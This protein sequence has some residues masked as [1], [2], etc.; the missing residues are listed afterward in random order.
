M[1]DFHLSNRC[2]MAKQ[3]QLA[4]PETLKRSEPL[5]DSKRQLQFSA[6]VQPSTLE[7]WLTPLFFSY[8]LT[9]HTITLAQTIPSLG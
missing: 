5:C 9:H 7:T 3:L 4:V 8:P 6:A 1:T 2:E